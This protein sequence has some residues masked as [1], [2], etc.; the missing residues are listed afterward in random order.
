M[1]DDWCRL[2]SCFEEKGYT[3]NISNTNFYSD[4]TSGGLDETSG[5]RGRV[6]MFLNINGKKV[7]LWDGLTIN[8]HGESVFG[9]SINQFSGTLLPVSTA[10][11]L[12]DGNRDVT[13]L[14]N[15]TL[16]QALSESVLVQAGKINTLDGFVQPFTGGANGLDGFQ[17]LALCFNPVLV[18]AFPYSS[19]G[20][21]MVVLDENQE[22]V[23]SAFVYDAN[24]TPTVSGF[25]TFFDNGVSLFASATLPTKLMNKPGH[26]MVYGLYSSGTYNSLDPNPYFDPGQGVVLANPDKTGSWLLAYAFDQA[27]YVS[28]DDPTR[29]WGVFG[30]VGIADDNPNPFNWA[31]NIGVGGSN[32]IGNRPQDTFGIGYF[33][34]GVSEPLKQIAPILLPL[35][36]EQGVEMFYNVGVTPWCHVTADLQVVEPSRERA[37]TLLMFGLRAK[38]DL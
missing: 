18:T 4:I 22:A 30:N 23:F 8:L 29:S 13:A 7:G 32:P 37:D 5:Y 6:D 3:W 10:Q 20:A 16:T 1:S 14:T 34:T 38:I 11:I 9:S 2:G 36:D 17:N 26:Q 21:G 31:A 24:N 12:P 35:Q 27:L 28:P 19:F 33:Y 15:V 25:D